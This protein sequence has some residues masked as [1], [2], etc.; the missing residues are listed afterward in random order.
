MRKLQ[1]GVTNRAHHK[2]SVARLV[3]HGVGRRLLVDD[4][5][6]LLQL[7]Q[8]GLVLGQE[9]GVVPR[10]VLD[11]LRPHITPCCHDTNTTIECILVT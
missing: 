11:A 6:L 10:V 1:C 9:R 2:R 8:G 3:V 5:L 4:R 7:V